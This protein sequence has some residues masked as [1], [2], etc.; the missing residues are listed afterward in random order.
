MDPVKK[1]ETIYNI[2]KYYVYNFLINAMFHTPVFV[3]L[4]QGMGLSLTSIMFLQSIAFVTVFL[5]EVPSGA[6]ADLWGRK[7]TIML[8]AGLMALAYLTLY[9][10]GNFWLLL[11]GFFLLGTGRSFCS[12][13]D[14]AFIYD[15]L[16]QDD[17]EPVFKKVKGTGFA[18]FLF[19]SVVAAVIGGYAGSF[20][21]RIPY[22]FTA[23]AMALAFV[24]IITFKEPKNL[25]NLT[26]K[27][28][29]LQIRD[30]V[31]FAFHHPRV[32]WLTLFSGFVL[33]F[34]ISRL[35]LQ[36]PFMGNMGIDI[37]WFGWIYAVLFLVSGVVSHYAQEIEQRIG[38]ERSFVLIGGL[39]VISFIVL[40]LFP[41]YLW[42]ISF[43]FLQQF[44]IGY[45]DP[46]FSDYINRLVTFDKRAT[47]LSVRSLVG[48]VI[49]FF[50]LV[51]TGLLSDVYG[52]GN[53][54]VFS[55]LVLLAVFAGLI[56]SQKRMEV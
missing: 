34:Y 18:M 7:K 21:L 19:G 45:Y 32:M 54:F 40:G 4:F 49:G 28:Y 12:G 3:L 22:L 48:T 8:G 30:G 15:S 39:M 35:L 43:L 29:F 37:A 5:F 50:V 51:G 23:A 2:R 26:V 1:M 47:V 36:Q 13:A 52:I 25:K 27:H 6:L 24:V 38:E 31:S 33:S 14:T 56:W 41:S 53:T 9:T 20:D 42:V 16:S 46:V 44:V 11:A 10:V 55:G 17:M